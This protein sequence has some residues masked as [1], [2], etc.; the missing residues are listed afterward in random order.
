MARNHLIKKILK[1]N[2]DTID[3]IS[4]RMLING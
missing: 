4:D 2:D 1:N 3:F